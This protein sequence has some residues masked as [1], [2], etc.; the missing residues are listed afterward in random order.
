VKTV[1]TPP[2]DD[3]SPR[4]SNGASKVAGVKNRQATAIREMDV[5]QSVAG[6][7]MDGVSGTIAST[8]VE[9]Q[10]SLAALSAKLVEQLQVLGNVEEAIKLKREELQQLYNIEAGAV[11]LDD[12]DAKIE[13]QREA[14]KEEQARKQR[15]FAEQQSERNKQ[16]ARTEEEYQYRMSQEHKQS[17]DAFAYQMGQREKANRDKQELLE[18][19]W[20]QREEE[21]K[22]REKELEDLRTQVAAIPEQVRKAENAAVAVATNSVKKEYETKIVLATKDAEMASKLAAQEVA[23]LRQALE[24][25]TA[26]TADLKTQLDQAH[27][28]VKEISAK[29]LESASGRSAME[30]LQKVLEKDPATYK[31]GK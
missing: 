21:L 15:E 19:N 13:A 22:K 6:L 24:K 20:G 18:K 12:L 11:S 26:Q 27:H 1:V 23:S 30:A 8:Q 9:V 4:P 29:A 16:W 10:K 5:L 28:D 17:E 7:N 14:W 31:T 3:D 2:D 25:A